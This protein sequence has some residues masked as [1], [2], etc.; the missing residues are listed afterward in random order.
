[1]LNYTAGPVGQAC[2]DNRQFIKLIM[3]PVGGGKSTVALMDLAQRAVLQKPFNGVRRTKFGILRNTM[4]QLKST[5]KPVIDQWFC[6]MTDN[7]MGQW[8]L[9]D[10][11]FEARFKLPDGTIVHSE[12]MLVPAD[13]K[14]DVRRLLS[15]ELSAGWIEEAREV[16]D[17]VFRGFR[18]R[19]NRFPNMASGGV[20]YP[21]LIC[22]TNPPPLAGFWHDVITNPPDN[23]AVFIQPPALLE[24][25]TVNP[26]AE[27]LKNLAADYYPNLMQGATEDWINVYLKNMFGAGDLGR[28]LYKDT[29]KRSFHVATQPLRAIKDTRYPL[30]V[31]L[32]NGLQAAATVGQQDARGRVNILGEAF[33]PED[34][35]MGVETFLDSICIPMLR[36]RFPGFGSENIV[37]V[38]D[39]A[40]FQRSQVDEKT[41]AQAVMN[42]GYQVVKASTNDPERRQQAVE[43][44]LT[45]QIDGTAGFLVDPSC[46]HIIDALEWGHRYKVVS[47]RSTTEAEKNHFSHQ[48]DSVQYMALHYNVQ[49]DGSAYRRNSQARPVVRSGFVYA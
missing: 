32:D 19:T 45:R 21:G 39:P 4:L 7:R 43:G 3:G 5:V 24:D 11:V 6:A 23:M 9:T 14:E 34:R 31:G 29:F 8:R 42:R 48:G 38:L 33:V 13:S 49:I 25:G 47:G 41:I 26:D 20:T 2:L 1:L 37:F 28:P 35:T 12:Y 27:N 10:N 40:C 22:S 30:I 18:G 44:L 15:L 16:N 36:N 46:T 17:E